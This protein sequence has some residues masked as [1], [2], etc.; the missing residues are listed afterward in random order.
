MAA[1]AVGGTLLV[2]GHHPSDLATG[3]ARPPMPDLFYL[4]EEI[5]A[6]LDE[7]WTVEVSEA[8]PRPASTPDGVQV[9]IHDAV[10]VATREA[11]TARRRNARQSRSVHGLTAT[12]PLPSAFMDARREA[13]R[14]VL[15]GHWSAVIAKWLRRHNSRAHKTR[16]PLPDSQQRG[17][18]RTTPTVPACGRRPSPGGPPAVGHSPH[19]SLMPPQPCRAGC[20]SLHAQSAERSVQMT[21]AVAAASASAAPSR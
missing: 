12:Q 13:R 4:P 7:E 1:V 18:P 20:A 3:V 21:F 6:L 5:A 15:S 17:G 11:G 16:S 2:V 9:T 19:R 14:A 8:R 10:L